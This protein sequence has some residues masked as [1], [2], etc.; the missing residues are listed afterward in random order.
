MRVRLRDVGR[1]EGEGRGREGRGGDCSFHPS[2]YLSQFSYLIF[3]VF[4]CFFI[5]FHFR[6]SLWT[7]STTTRNN[8]LNNHRTEDPNEDRMDDDSD[9]DTEGQGDDGD[10]SSDNDR[11]SDTWIQSPPTQ[12]TSPTTINKNQQQ[13]PQTKINQHQPN[14]LQFVINDCRRFY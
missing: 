10:K 9:G 5:F 2:I 4:H 8:N 13:L 1:Q 14:K 12:S 6:Q 11:N 3:L 7:T